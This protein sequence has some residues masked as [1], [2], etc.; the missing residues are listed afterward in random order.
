M[1]PWGV[2]SQM[3][4]NM[5]GHAAV[6]IGNSQVLVYGGQSPFGAFPTTV[7][8]LDYDPFEWKPVVDGGSGTV[9]AGRMFHAMGYDD[10]GNAMYVFGGQGAAGIFDDCWKY[11]VATATWALLPAFGASIPSGR[12]NMAH[13]TVGRALYVYGGVTASGKVLDDLWAL[14]MA[15]GSWAVVTPVVSATSESAQRTMHRPPGLQHATLVAVNGTNLVLYGGTDDLGIQRSDLYVF[16]PADLTWTLQS[17]STLGS[18]PPPPVERMRGI[19]VDSRRV[20]FTG[21]LGAN[22]ALNSTWVWKMD[23]DA[24]AANAY[25]SLPGTLHSHALVAFNQSA[26]ANACAWT[27]PG[28]PI[29]T[30]STNFTL[31]AISGATNNPG[32]GVVVSFANQDPL[33][34]P[35]GVLDP[36]AKWAVTVLNGLGLV[37]A[38]LLFAFVAK[39]RTHRV[40][41]ASNP[42]F[43]ALILIGA[44]LAHVGIIS[45]TW[46]NDA[47][48]SYVLTSFL[49]GAGYSLI[50]SS[51][52]VKTFV[53]Y[54]YVFSIRFV[55][56]KLSQPRLV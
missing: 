13:A 41:K 30:P 28:L 18:G 39:H 21:G 8:M 31:V 33:P 56:M 25:G 52:V 20:I 35:V 34:P 40:I 17:P 5:Q 37:S 2:R 55:V 10:A 23:E 12:T 29:C 3:L 54:L 7:M 44:A 6:H 15:D 22:G 4:P 32:G 38:V 11:S 46:Q 42:R 43:S 14:N 27:I 1:S 16:S 47:R 9:P 50:F 48:Y 49:V 51:L 19:S 53:L 36:G 45:S 26:N 24:W